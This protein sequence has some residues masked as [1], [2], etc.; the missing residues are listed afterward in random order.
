MSIAS[1][2]PYHNLTELDRLNTQLRT[3]CMVKDWREKKHTEY[4]ES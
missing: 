3:L 2:L 4:S 1:R